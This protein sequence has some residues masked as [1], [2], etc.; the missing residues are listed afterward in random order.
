MST[1][2]FHHDEFSF[3]LSLAGFVAAFLALW[4]WPQSDCLEW[5]AASRSTQTPSQRALK[6]ISTWM[7]VEF[8][9]WTGS[10]PL[11]NV[12]SLV[13]SWF[14][15][16]AFVPVHVIVFF[17]WAQS[18]IY[19][20]VESVFETVEEEKEEESTLTSR[21]CRYVCCPCLFLSKLYDTVFYFF[22]IHEPLSLLFSCFHC[23][24]V[25]WTS[26]EILTVLSPLLSSFSLC[27]LCLCPL[28]E[29][30][31]TISTLFGGGSSEPTPNVTEPV[32]VFPR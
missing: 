13:L 7:K 21:F 32:Q 28:L 14:V 19:P 3:S 10:V 1:A 4:T 22:K 23:S 5:A 27:D 6:L 11:R 15:C 20:Q 8:F 25:I 29:L 9:C 17:F 30:G 26:S 2:S 24:C 18:S 31:N 16:W 12:S